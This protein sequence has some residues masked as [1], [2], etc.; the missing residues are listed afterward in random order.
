MLCFFPLGELGRMQIGNGIALKINDFFVAL[1]IVWWLLY[2]VSHKKARLQNNTLLKPFL[3]FLG[4]CVL[5]LLVNFSR[6]SPS[7]IFV[8]FMYLIRFVLYGLLLFVVAEFDQKFKQRIITLLIWIGGIVVGIGFFQYAFYQDLHS[9]FYLGWDE[10]MYRMFSSFLDPN[11]A[12]AFFVLYLMFLFGIIFDGFKKI[13]KKTTIFFGILSLLTFFSILLTY[14]RSALIMFFVSI[15]IF[16]IFTKNKKWIFGVVGVLVVFFVLASRNFYVENLNLF[17][18]VSS[19]ARIVSA[20]NAIQIIQKNPLIGVGF[21]TYKYA[22]VEYGYR[23]EKGIK[24]SHA[25]GSTDN[26]FLFVLVTTGIIGFAAYLF[27]WFV[28][29]KRLS[30]LSKSKHGTQSHYF[31]IAT[32]AAI[33][34]LFIDALFINSLFYSFLMEWFF[35]VIGLTLIDYR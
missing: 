18:V 14:S 31:I 35:I 32:I 1:T 27:F 10:H 15:S 17:R 24:T 19:E 22:Q 30:F 26:S 20:Q 23:N 3:I 2:Y 5:S 9:L 16:L 11:F 13:N 21:S 28:I 6:F 29:L 8:S 12:G 25:D 4:I 7:E 33:G 34:G